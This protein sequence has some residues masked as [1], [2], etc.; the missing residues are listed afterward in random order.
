[1][2]TGY[3]GEHLEIRSDALDDLTLL[4]EVHLQVLFSSHC[5]PFVRLA[6][7]AQIGLLFAQGVF[8]IRTRVD[9]DL[10]LTQSNF[11]HIVSDLHCFLTA[12]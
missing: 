2:I 4:F 8:Y 5:F 12:S 10:S 6:H 1:M 11:C 3:C 9:T 7:L